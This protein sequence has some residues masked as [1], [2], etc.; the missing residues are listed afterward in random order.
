M[1]F[2]D[3]SS[4]RSTSKSREL[5]GQ[6]CGA[7]LAR[8]SNRLESETI[9]TLTETFLPAHEVVQHGTVIV[10]SQAGCRGATASTLPKQKFKCE[11]IATSST[12]QLL[13]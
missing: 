6:Q 11:A 12:V 4:Y 8:M 9:E 3:G 7:V 5:A 13:R 1:I 10:T 2:C